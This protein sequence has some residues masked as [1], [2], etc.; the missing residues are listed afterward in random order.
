MTQYNCWTAYVYFSTAHTA[1]QPTQNRIQDNIRSNKMQSVVMTE[2]YN[3]N[4]SVLLVFRKVA[5]R[6]RKPHFTVGS[7]M[8]M[9]HY[10]T[11]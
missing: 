1:V 8:K 2:T 7:H 9:K 5:P 6:A 4:V 3:W 10:V 11:F